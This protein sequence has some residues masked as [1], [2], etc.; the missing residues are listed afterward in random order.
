MPQ[1]SSSLNALIERLSDE[2]KGVWKELLRYADDHP[3]AL[4]ELQADVFTDEHARALNVRLFLL[5]EFSDRLQRATK[6][7]L[8]LRNALL[9]VYC[10]A[11]ALCGWRSFARLNAVPAQND[12]AFEAFQADVRLG[13]SGRK[14]ALAF[15]RIEETAV[16]LR[17]GEFSFGSFSEPRTLPDYL[18][19]VSEVRADASFRHFN[20]DVGQR[21]Y[22]AAIWRRLRYL[23]GLPFG[24][25]HAELT[26]G[27]QALSKLSPTAI[28][29]HPAEGAQE[30]TQSRVFAAYLKSKNLSESTIS[31]YRSALNAINAF[32][33]EHSGDFVFSSVYDPETV[34]D[35][36][37]LQLDLLIHD[38]FIEMNKRNHNMYSSALKQFVDFVKSGKLLE[39]P[40]QPEP[41][42]SSAR[43]VERRERP[44]RDI[45]VEQ[46]LR[47]SGWHCEHD[48]A[49]VTF[50]TDEGHEYMEG[51]H[52]IPVW[53]QPNFQ[54]SLHVWANI[55][56]LCPTCHRQIH[57]G[58]HDERR[59]LFR[60]LYDQRAERFRKVGIDQ[61][62]EELVEMVIP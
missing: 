48:H 55:F 50:V 40:D 32:L 29:A 17:P 45:V 22:S 47:L 30:A 26:S 42:K 1:T 46:S 36:E 24:E 20:Y 59:E 13:G 34:E 39:L 2:S 11:G 43:V 35:L 41:V 9:D 7:N 8:P 18:K 60:E 16:A 62:R 38:A 53:A 4:P 25:N 6:A 23:T 33:R 5:P 15:Q 14:Y 31:H 10:A 44:R 19:F 49:H 57:Y 58:R 27:Q 56:S 61:T 28:A 3:G 51:H 52:L 21:M 12:P 37:D 54:V